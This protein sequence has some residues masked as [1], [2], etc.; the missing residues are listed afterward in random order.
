MLSSSGRCRRTN[1]A[2]CF[3]RARIFPAVLGLDARG[4]RGVIILDDISRAGLAAAIH[5]AA[6]LR[7]HNDGS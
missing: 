5:A 6:T 2:R 1:R 3:Q 7:G 4:T